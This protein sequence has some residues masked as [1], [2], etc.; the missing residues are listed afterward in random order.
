MTSASASQAILV[1]KKTLYVSGTLGMDPQ[2]Q[3]VCGGAEAQARQVLTNMKHVLEA[4]GASI[5]SVIKTT[6]LLQ[7]MADFQAVNQVYSEFFT[8]DH[9]ARATFQ[10]AKLPA[11]AAVEIEAIA[12]SGD[13]VVAEAGPCPCTRE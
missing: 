3:L 12:L 7:D 5:E 4:G 13:L 11:G 1:D 10:V 8:K 9:P 2:G 6:I